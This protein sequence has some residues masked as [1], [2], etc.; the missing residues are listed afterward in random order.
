[1][2]APTLGTKGIFNTPIEAAI[3]FF[4]NNLAVLSILESDKEIKPADGLSS[5]TRPSLY[6]KVRLC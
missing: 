1:M 2:C 3:F 6:K 4:L 5:E